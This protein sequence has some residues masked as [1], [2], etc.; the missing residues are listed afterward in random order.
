MKKIQFSAGFLFL[1]SWLLYRDRSGIVL[2]GII[3][4]LLHE[5][6]H[7]LVLRHFNIDVTEIRIT[8]FGAKIKLARTP[9]YIQEFFAAAAGPAV[10]LILAYLF[11]SSS[12][13]TVFAGINLSLAVFNLLP[14][15]QLDGARILRCLANLLL[16]QRRA[17]QLCRILSSLA[18]IVFLFF[19]L[20]AAFVWQNITLLLMC[21][22]VFKNT[23]TEKST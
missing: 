21:I 23:L 15:S 2:Q 5:S 19:G 4:C 3:A 9:S 22:W 11:C 8:C 14:V 1:C 13:G 16:C 10:N 18:A 17:N 7:C 6:G 20:Y 12:S